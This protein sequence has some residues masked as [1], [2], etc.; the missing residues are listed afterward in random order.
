MNV[1]TFTIS[2]SS[3]QNGTG[4]KASGLFFARLFFTTILVVLSSL[5]VKSDVPDAPPPVPANR[6]L[7]F[8]G[9][10]LVVTGTRG[11]QGVSTFYEY[12]MRNGVNLGRTQILTHPFGGPENQESGFYALSYSPNGNLLAGN[13]GKRIGPTT[14]RDLGFM[15]LKTRKVRRLTYGQQISP[16]EWSPDSGNLLAITCETLLTDVDY[17]LPQY[18]NLSKRKL[19]ILNTQTGAVKEIDQQVQAA[20]WLADGR[21][22]LYTKGTRKGKLT[23]YLDAYKANDRELASA[24]FFCPV[25][26]AGVGKPRRVSYAE[27]TRLVGPVFP[28]ALPKGSNYYQQYSER[29]FL[30]PNGKKGFIGLPSKPGDSPPD[31]FTP[32]IDNS[33]PMFQGPTEDDYIRYG[34]VNAKGI[35]LRRRYQYYSVALRSGDWQWGNQSRFVFGQSNEDDNPFGKCLIGI[36]SAN[37]DVS[38]LPFTALKLPPNAVFSIAAL[39][40]DGTPPPAAHHKKGK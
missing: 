26:K 4:A 5:A 3:K 18:A 11:K 33:V 24:F 2:R 6:K 12:R 34:F 10:L 22:V 9:K 15:D 25:S 32:S 21:G 38:Y 28:Y 29:S 8:T 30:S 31:N 36:N 23:T 35:Y 19:L 40:G 14:Y 16:I 7:A 20:F 1:L 39:W 13:F 37:G 17:R 27:A